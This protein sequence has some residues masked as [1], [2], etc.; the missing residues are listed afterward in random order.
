MGPVKEKTGLIGRVFTLLTGIEDRRCFSAGDP[1][2]RSIL[3][4][5]ES[6]ANSRITPSCPFSPGETFGLRLAV[7]A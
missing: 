2:Q 5:P 4:T 6:V 7:R 3:T 1:G